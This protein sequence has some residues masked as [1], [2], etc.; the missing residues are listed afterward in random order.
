MFDNEKIDAYQFTLLVILFVVGDALLYVPSWLA[1]SAKQDAW[2]AAGFGCVEGLAI[3]WLYTALA[4]RYF[5]STLIEICRSVF[6]RWAGTAAACLFVSF[7]LVDI[8]IMLHEIGDFITTQMIPETPIEVVILLFT[9]VIVLGVRLG[10]VTLVRSS[11]LAFPSFMLLY[12][13]LILFISPQIKLEHAQ[14]VLSEGLKP[15]IEGNLRFFGNLEESV[16]LLMLF[17]FARSAVRGAKAYATGLTIGTILLTLFSTVSILVMG[18]DITA[19]LAYPSYV[20][21]QKVSVGKFFERIEAIMAFLWFITVFVKISVCYYAASYGIAQIAKL[22]KYHT[23]TLPLAMISIVLAL[24]FVP[25]RPYFDHFATKFWTP[26]TLTF[27]LFLPLLM[28]GAAWLR[29]SLG[30]R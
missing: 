6:G 24:V 19:L 25:N 8:S 29:Q 28:L 7:I 3:A 1:S 11:E 5:P 27:G 13:L 21:A 23:V 18:S 12:L 4:K 22:P 26:Y 20:L 15:V 14:P 2:L 16:I 30:K 17:P 10:A 9:G